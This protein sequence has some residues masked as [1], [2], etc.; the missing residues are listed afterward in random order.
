[1]KNQIKWLGHSAFEIRTS[2][3]KRILIDPW[4]SGNPLNGLNVEEFLSPDLIQVTHDH[5]DHYGSDIPTLLKAS[6]GLLFGQP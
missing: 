5:H 4:L 1:M 2:K 6:E 3:R